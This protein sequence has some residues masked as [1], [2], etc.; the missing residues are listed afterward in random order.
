M[1]RA[2]PAPLCIAH[3]QLFSTSFAAK[4]QRSCSKNA[5]PASKPP[6][7]DL[8]IIRPRHLPQLPPDTQEALSFTRFRSADT[9]LWSRQVIIIRNEPQRPRRAAPASRQTTGHTPR[10]SAPAGA[11]P[12]MGGT[13]PSPDTPGGPAPHLRVFRTRATV[14]AVTVGNALPATKHQVPEPRRHRNP[15]SRSRGDPER[16]WG[17]PSGPLTLTAVKPELMVGS[18]GLL[19]RPA[20]RGLRTVGWGACFGQS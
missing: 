3:V 4:G 10:R 9:L 16:R 8:Y 14:S 20:R 15:P 5:S 12:P 11:E 2:Q 1:G 6:S 7:N 17:A 19:V 18:T 13:P